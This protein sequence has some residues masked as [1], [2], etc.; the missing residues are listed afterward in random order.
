MLVHACSQINHHKAKCIFLPEIKGNCNR[1]INTSNSQNQSQYHLFTSNYGEKI[2][3]NTNQLIK[4]QMSAVWALEIICAKWWKWQFRLHF[5]L[6]VIL[7]SL[8]P[9]H[10]LC[11]TRALSRILRMSLFQSLCTMILFAIY[12]SI[13]LFSCMSHF[14]IALSLSISLCFG[15]SSCC[16]SVV[17]CIKQ[18]IF[19]AP[20]LK[21]NTNTIS[22]YL[23][24]FLNRIK[25]KKKKISRQWPC[26]KILKNISDKRCTRCNVQLDL[27]RTVD[28]AWI[29][30]YVK[31]G[32]WRSQR[33]S[34]FKHFGI[35]LWRKSVFFLCLRYL[36]VE[37]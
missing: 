30:F 36:S 4:Q 35:N 1:Q 33:V 34:E 25:C 28:C 10:T 37:H 5:R 18:I 29:V 32:S 16:I 15:R 17:T 3:F 11:W 22:L 27:L 21:F 12:V 2:S 24:H 14:F 19:M 7:F 20:N 13:C 9:Y 8:K 31:F 23:W 26:T 6:K